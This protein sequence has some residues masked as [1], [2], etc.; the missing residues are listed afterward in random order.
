[1]IHQ[2]SPEQQGVL[3]L[4]LD[5]I[6]IR[7]GA[8]TGKTTTV[9]MVVANLVNTKQVEPERVLGITFTN[10]AAAELS[11]RIRENLASQIDDGRQVEV[12]TYHGF[13]T[14]VLSEFASLAGLSSR[15]RVI[16]PTFSR[17]LIGERFHRTRYD[18]LD[19]TSPRMIDRIRMLGDR[20]ADQLLLPADLPRLLDD[21][22]DVAKSRAEMLATLEGYE[23]DKLRLG[24]VDY[25]DL[26]LLS[27]RLMI[28]HPLLAAEVR[29]RYQVVVLDEYQDTN[30]AQRVLFN[31]IFGN[32]FPVIA[33]GDE[34]QTIYEWRGASAENF[35]MFLDHFPRSGGQHAH[36]LS[37]TTNRRSAPEILEVANHVRLRANPVANRLEPHGSVVGGQ[38]ITAWVGDAVAE[39]DFVAARF[40]AL[41]Q[42]GAP[43]KSMAVLFRKNKDFAVVVDAMRRADIPVE[44]A[45]LGGLLSVP[46]ISDLRSWL[47]ILER[48]GDSAAV[49]QILLGSRYRLGLADIA[50]L[51]AWVHSQ[52]LDEDSEEVPAITILE[53]IEHCEEIEL[54]EEARKTLTHFFETYRGILVESQGVSLV[55]TC[56]LVLDR[57]NAWGDMDSLP[58][59]QR[60]T[61]RLNIY[62]MLDLAEDWSPLGGR[63]SL[64]AFLEY[65]EAM[66]DEPAEELDSAHLSGEDAVTLV[67][68]HR[69]K[70]LEW[71][72]VAVPVV[73]HQSFPGRSIQ[74]P[75]PLRFAEYVPPAFRI[76]HLLD[77]MP[78]DRQARDDFFKERNDIQE[79]RI[80]YVATTRAKHTLIVTGAYWYG[81]PE[82]KLKPS[83]PSELFEMVASHAQV[84]V[85]THEE[86]P[87]RPA[88]LAANEA[89]ASP[90]PLFRGGWNEALR[91]TVETETTMAD[92]AES[93]GVSVE[94]EEEVER[95]TDRLFDL[96]RI[97]PAVTSE[98]TR[99]VSVTGLVTYAQC[100]KRFY[101]SDVDPLPRRRNP[102]A[103][104]G[105]EFHR[106]IELFH[107][108]QVP[109]DEVEPDLYDVPEEA[110]G[111][112]GFHVFRESR[113]A[114]KQPALVEAPFELEL[115]NGY[116]VRG[117]ID[118]V[119]DDEGRWEIVDFKSGRPSTDDA[120]MVQLEAYA[121]AGLEVDFGLDTPTTMDVT[122][123]YFGGGLTI[124]THHADREWTDTARSHLGALTA[125]ISQAAFEERPGRWCAH[126]DF[127]G[128]CSPG[129]VW[130]S[131]P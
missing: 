57:T 24:V 105:T 104:A 14:Q 53:A 58:K 94:F 73:V 108:G 11:D 66:E 1:M 63:P 10:K 50:P 17:Q 117:R 123:A 4:G 65:L 39:A 78:E 106:R 83:K 22:D 7:A 48:P 64:G 115:D 95:L 42:E 69:A 40:E 8:G 52:D 109:F 128:F 56:R 36:D 112:G 130:T 37:L 29:S 114:A 21:A 125:D 54:R 82:P 72:I 33:V 77:E 2:P 74:H 118:A 81:L 5:S 111:P 120:R 71:D 44:V 87:P 34:D 96:G 60:L 85:R 89:E 13:A 61:A 110:V 31:T 100:P 76:D 75:D 116:R 47:T 28:L 88:I 45:N 99:V 19:I 113:F 97:E 16:T 3:D 30:P 124:E 79:W 23:A 93:L 131:R 102:A 18:Q 9:A 26:V 103:I 126:C 46:E 15:I 86:A 90:D 32:G 35:E 92:L 91:R 68:V 84:N 67:T 27:S 59:N 43:W 51:S 70:G 127:L 41:H 80:A 119:Y 129:Q 38:V 98:R 12:H 107:R 55:E 121:V 20:L 25:G 122:F 62:R 6:R 49:A 101:W